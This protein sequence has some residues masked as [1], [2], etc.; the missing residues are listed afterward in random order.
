MSAIFHCQFASVRFC[1]ES[2]YDDRLPH[3]FKGL[4][5][6][7][8]GP[9]NKPFS[10]TRFQPSSAAWLFAMY[11]MA[12][13]VAPAIGP[14]LGGWITDNYNWHWIFFI[15]VPIGILSL[16]VDEACGPRS[17]LSQESQAFLPSELT[18]LAWP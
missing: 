15:N 2:S 17:G 10:R 4:G 1:D 16:L 14:T 6:A 18:T 9:P 5:V 11:G 7:D 13:V 12:V 3:C 8:W